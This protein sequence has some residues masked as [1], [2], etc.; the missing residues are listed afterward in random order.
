[1][2]YRNLNQ[3]LEREGV[4]MI[5]AQGERF[6][7]LWH[8]AVGTV[9]H[10]DADVDPQTVIEVMEKGYRLGERVIRPARVIVAV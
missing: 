3:M 1:M 6:D 7:P 9:S 10:E 4:Q 5:E 8:E 2:T